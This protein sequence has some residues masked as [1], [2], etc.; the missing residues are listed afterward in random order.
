MSNRK[1]RT[2]DVFARRADQA[3]IR[4]QKPAE[5]ETGFLK[6]PGSL[7]YFSVLWLSAGRLISRLLQNR[8]QIYGQS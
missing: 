7:V 5:K 8:L 1:L 2:A 6:N 3:G 4:I